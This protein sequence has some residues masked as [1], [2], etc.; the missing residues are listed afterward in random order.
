MSINEVI[1]I[2][3]FSNTLLASR[4]MEAHSL[5]PSPRVA[6]PEAAA[7]LASIMIR[8]LCR[9]SGKIHNATNWLFY[10]SP[11]PGPG[12]GS[13]KCNSTANAGPGSVPLSAIHTSAI[14]PWCTW[15]RLHHNGYHRGGYSSVRTVNR[16]L[17][18]YLSLMTFCLLT[19]DTCGLFG[20]LLLVIDDFCQI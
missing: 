18:V 17:F 11:G 9:Y 19:Y 5:F 3:I 12:P 20:Y 6:G 2:Q 13:A 7:S 4:H 15:I 16:C 10:T 14:C 1:K 8:L